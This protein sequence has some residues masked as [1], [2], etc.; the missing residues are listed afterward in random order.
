MRGT[1][2]TI[3]FGLQTPQQGVSY[4][5][6]RDHW[7][8]LE[9]LGY[10]SVWMPDHLFAVGDEPGAAQLECWT[11]LAALARETSTIRFGPL[12]ACHSYRPPALTAKIAA[13]LDVLSNGRL[14]FGYGYGWYTAEYAGYGYDY[15]ADRV[16]SAEFGEALDICRRLWTEERVTFEGTYYHLEQAYCAPKPV[17][18][19]LPIMIGGSGPKYTLPWVAKYADMWNT[20]GTPQEVTERIGHLRRACEAIGRDPAEICITWTGPIVMD[21]DEAR[22]ARRLERRG[23]KNAPPGPE[24][25]AVVGTPPQV[26]ERLQTYVDLGVNGFI[27]LFGRLENHASTEM[28]AAEVMPHFRATG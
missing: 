8:L 22:L 3:V 27:V 15:P 14:I 19:P 13:T 9:R 4:E 25:N 7:Q 6:I 12:V 18:Q 2:R 21:N 10:D 1:E 20:S 23:L 5:V 28:F 16:R 24:Q 26:R 17:Q 11:T